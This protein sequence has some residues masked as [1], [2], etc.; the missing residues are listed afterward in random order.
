MMNIL[1][2]IPKNLFF[3]YRKEKKVWHVWFGQKPKYAIVEVCFLKFLRLKEAFKKPIGK[4]FFKEFD[5]GKFEFGP[6]KG[7]Y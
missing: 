2:Q 7:V 5:Q 3:T 6:S 4:V 1:L